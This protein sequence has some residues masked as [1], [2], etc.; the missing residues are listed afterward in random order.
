MGILG[1]VDIVGYFKHVMVDL[2]GKNL[3]KKKV[4]IF[5]AL[6]WSKVYP[7]PSHLHPIVPPFDC[8]PMSHLL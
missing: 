2:K 4:P 6:E 5:L 1:E 3:I 7:F 8:Y